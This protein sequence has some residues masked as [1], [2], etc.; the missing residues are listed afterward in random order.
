[1]S[2]ARDVHDLSAVLRSGR[3]SAMELVQE[4]FR[5]IDERNATVNA[6]VIELREKA[7]AKAKDA[8]AARARGHWL[9]PL[10]GIPVTIKES[11]AYVGTASTWGDR[12]RRNL[13]SSRTAVAVERL[14]A[15]GAI[16]VGKTNVPFMLTDWQ[17]Y[18]DLYG[19][20]THPED[21]RLTA[22]GSSGGESAA[23][24]ARFSWLG[25]G[26]DIGGSIR[27][28]AYCCG[29]FGHKP[30]MGFVSLEGH[31]PGAWHGEPEPEAEL[32][33]AGPLALSARDLELALSV[34]G[35][36]RPPPPRHTRLEDFRVG[37]VEEEDCHEAVERLRRAGARLEAGWPAGVDARA[38]F[39]TYRNLLD[40]FLR[41][42][43]GTDGPPDHYADWHGHLR[44]AARWKGLW[45]EYFRTHD[46][47]LMPVS[48]TRAFPHD[49]GPRDWRTLGYTGRVIQTERGLRAYDDLLWWFAPASLLGLPATTT[50]D[51][52]Q[53]LAPMG[54]DLTGIHLAELL[55]T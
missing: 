11:F 14:E 44:A 12:E 47:F 19:V 48:F 31:V 49:H 37:Y 30:T 27:F 54:E 38:Q 7:F 9:G 13:V 5:R 22:G 15:A 39:S 50:P 18:N 28:P 20:T 17:T 35:E 3:A 52:V 16:V 42:V 25:L 41:A 53:I 46:A 21:P 1:L 2:L 55:T 24:A 40:I 36:W 23:L 51:G 33:V 32:P 43:M 34:L 4:C 6:V 29:L 45:R 10:H 8:D 26:S